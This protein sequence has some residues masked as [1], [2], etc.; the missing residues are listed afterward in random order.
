MEFEIGRILLATLVASV[1]WFVLGYVLYMNPM[2]AKIYKAFEDKGKVKK[3]KSTGAMMGFLILIIVV[4]AF[5]W[6]VLYAFVK[7]LLPT[8][9]V[10]AGLLFGVILVITKNIP[11]FLDMHLGAI[12]PSRLLT[13]ELVNGIISSL[14]RTELALN[15]ATLN[16][17]SSA[18]STLSRAARGAGT[19]PICPSCPATS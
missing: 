10:A 15:V 1:V 13:I 19:C 9:L 3:W 12:H 18:W 7:P 17:R 6:A 16:I 8:M 14:V 4:Q 11:K 2:V 5:L